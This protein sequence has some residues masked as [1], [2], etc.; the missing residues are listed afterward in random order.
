MNKFENFDLISHVLVIILSPW[1][2]R[3]AQRNF[4]VS[5]LIFLLSLVMFQYFYLFKS[6]NILLLIGLTVILSF[7]SINEGFDNSIFTSSAL[8]IQQYNKRHEF[9]AV[10]LGKIYTNRFSLTYFK[11]YNLPLFKLQRNI[12]STLDP[13]S[14]FLKGHP[15]ERSGI[16]EFKKYSIIFLPFFLIGTVYYIYKASSKILI[17]LLP[18]L[19]VSALVSPSFYLG[20]ILFFPVINLMITVGIVLSFK[21]LSHYLKGYFVK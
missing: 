18:I 7:V 1:W 8:D 4:L 2:W 15:R 19:L 10:D 16:D 20:P 21:T 13:N 9:Y 12:F 14:Y 17:Y 6:K 11:E 5:L 3:I